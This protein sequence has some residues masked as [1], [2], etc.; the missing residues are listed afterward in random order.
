MFM[1]R[2]SKG[3]FVFVEEPKL[4][5]H[6]VLILATNKR[7]CYYYYNNNNNYYYYYQFDFAPFLLVLESIL[8]R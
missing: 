6:E 7:A 3:E 2:R 8:H 4:F 1:A 5:N